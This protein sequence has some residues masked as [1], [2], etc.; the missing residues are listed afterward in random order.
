[1]GFFVR[2]RRLLA[3]N[4]PAGIDHAML[5]A[6]LDAHQA[7]S[8][9]ARAAAQTAGAGQEAD[10]DPLT[11]LLNGGPQWRAAVRAQGGRFSRAGTGRGVKQA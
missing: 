11:E 1:M 8:A 4:K 3:R 10:R 5:V 6:T 7:A 9:T 2:A